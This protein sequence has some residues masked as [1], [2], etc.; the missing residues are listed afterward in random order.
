MKRTAIALLLLPATAACQAGP[1]E[2]LSP[3]HEA[4]AGAV[5]AML[6]AGM[7]RHTFPDPDPG[8]PAYARLTTLLDQIFHYDG[9]VVIPFYRD[10]ACVPA[11]FNLLG[12]FDPPGPDGPGAFGCP[13]T[14]RGFYLVEAGSPQGTFPRISFSDGDAVP[15]WLVRQ[16]AF[17]AALETGRVT[18]A[19]LEAMSPRR[20]V[21]TSY[22]ETLRPRIG[23]H[24]VVI[25]ASGAL[26]D[27]A[28]FQFHVTHVEDVTRAIRLR[29]R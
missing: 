27:G 9:W 2:S 25:D 22:R 28:R 5:A 16:D 4:H 17:S 18:M 24:L 14:V 1:T 12:L 7:E 19:D 29:I 10:P 13:L 26:D 21:A 3:T 20:G 8:V 6:D 11:D 23:E 15:V